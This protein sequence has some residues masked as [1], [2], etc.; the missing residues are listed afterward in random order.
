MIK[1]NST[2]TKWDDVKLQIDLLYSNSKINIWWNSK[3]LKELFKKIRRVL[4]NKSGSN[5]RVQIFIHDEY[6]E[7]LVNYKFREGL[8]SK[9]KLEELADT[10]I[11]DINRFSSSDIKINDYRTD[12]ICRDYY[13]YNRI[14]DFKKTLKHTLDSAQNDINA[15]REYL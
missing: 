10:L 6:F 1:T 7:R 11:A 3:Q 2:W 9:L 5:Y 12:A 15:M 8:Y 14:E 13:N 4:L